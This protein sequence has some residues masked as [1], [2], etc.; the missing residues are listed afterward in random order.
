MSCRQWSGKN[1]QIENTTLSLTMADHIIT[2]DQI[3]T[4]DS[5]NLV[6]LF[7]E[8]N[9]CENENFNDSIYFTKKTLQLVYTELIFI[10]YLYNVTHISLFC[11]N[12]RRINAHWDPLQELLLN[13][14]KTSFLFDLIGLTEVIHIRNEISYNLTGYHSLQYSTRSDADDGRGGVAL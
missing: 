12:C 7:N 4:K 3:Q 14:N 10:K 13:M 5:L 1:W 2:I 6:T 8:A 11:L 9:Q